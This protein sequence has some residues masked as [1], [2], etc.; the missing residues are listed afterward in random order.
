MSADHS[1]MEEMPAAVTVTSADG[2][3]IAMNARAREAYASGRSLVGTN[4]FDCHPEPARRALARLYERQAASHYTVTRGGE[5]KIVHHLPTF[6]DGRFA[7]IVEI[8]I[9][10]PDDLPH[11]DRDAPGSKT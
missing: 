8:V 11:F 7:G 4:V 10:L 5:R 1:W 9:P 3:I 2:T 6:E